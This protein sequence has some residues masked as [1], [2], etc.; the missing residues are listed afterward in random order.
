MVLHKVDNEV[1][2]QLTLF[3]TLTPMNSYHMLGTKAYLKL[4][5]I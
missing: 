5:V 4:R 1:H 3:S 2:A